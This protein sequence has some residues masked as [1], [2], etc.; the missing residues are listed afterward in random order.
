[1]VVAT[2]H[3][4][5]GAAAGVRLRTRAKMM[6]V[7]ARAEMA[8]LLYADIMDSVDKM[9]PASDY[10]ICTPKPLIS[11]NI[12]LKPR[13]PQVQSNTKCHFCDIVLDRSLLNI[14]PK[15]DFNFLSWSR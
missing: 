10:Q 15:T 12:D 8:S 7:A 5:S 3:A 4:P 1:M 9:A 13:A 14:S 6:F 2:A 11:G